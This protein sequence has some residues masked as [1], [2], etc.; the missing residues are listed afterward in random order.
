[1]L[2]LRICFAP[3]IDLLVG[4]GG[5]GNRLTAAVWQETV[6]WKGRARVVKSSRSQKFWQNT[7][8]L[9]LNFGEKNISRIW[10]H[11]DICAFGIFLQYKFLKITPLMGPRCSWG[12]IFGSGC[13]DDIIMQIGQSKAIWQCK[14][15]NLVAT[16]NANGAI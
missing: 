6:E 12:P 2:L 3:L 13:D 14:L 1:M 11:V 7:T 8:C 5:T 9:A 4:V 10:G 16:N 15:R